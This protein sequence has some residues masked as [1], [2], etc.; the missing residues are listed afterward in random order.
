MFK[1]N[2]ILNFT[3]EFAVYISQ[4]NIHFDII[5]LRRPG[6]MTVIKF[7]VHRM[8]IKVSIVIEII[9]LVEV[10]AFLLRNNMIV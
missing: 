5:I 1:K 2:S 7:Y 6:L 10:S 9:E 3:S 8:V 4:I